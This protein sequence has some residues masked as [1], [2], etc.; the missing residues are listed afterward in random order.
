MELLRL[1]KKIASIDVG[2]KRIG[3]AFLIHGVSLPQDA[4]FRKNRDQASRDLLKV[5]NEWDINTLIV[6][7]PKDSSDYEVM[8][9]KIEHF[10]GLLKFDGEVFY[11]DES[12]SSFEAKE[13]MKG[14]IKQKRDGK[15]DS[16]SAKIILERWVSDNL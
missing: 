12:F 4:I 10:V 13:S 7:I 11:Q 1:C 15:I 3:L 8:K 5:L 16:I 14:N 9:K 6:G 2:E